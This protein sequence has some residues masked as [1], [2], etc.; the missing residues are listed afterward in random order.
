MSR[1]RIRRGSPKQAQLEAVRRAP[2]EHE[3]LLALAA[4][5]DAACQLCRGDG[6]NWSR[7]D[8][9]VPTS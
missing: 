2:L 7:P 9:S 1:D 8:C 3:L 6:P 5:G 4:G